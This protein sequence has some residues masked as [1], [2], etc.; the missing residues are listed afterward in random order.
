V[1]GYLARTPWQA[2]RCSLDLPIRHTQEDDIGTVHNIVRLAYVDAF[3]Q[4]GPKRYGCPVGPT[5]RDDGVSRIEQRS[6]K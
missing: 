6:R 5:C 2:C 1:C 4:L 3:G